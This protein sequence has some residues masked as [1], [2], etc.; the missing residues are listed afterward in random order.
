MTKLARNMIKFSLIRWLPRNKIDSI[1]QLIKKN[2]VLLILVNLILFYNVLILG[3]KNVFFFLYRETTV[4]SQLLDICNIREIVVPDRVS[5]DCLDP[6]IQETSPGKVCL[7]QQTKPSP[8][9]AQL[10]K[11]AVVE[12]QQQQ[13]KHALKVLPTHLDVTQQNLQ[14]VE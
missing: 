14:P 13:R 5:G 12:T 9:P 10:P 1:K 2:S 4:Y 3:R 11:R 6:G 7:G 8:R